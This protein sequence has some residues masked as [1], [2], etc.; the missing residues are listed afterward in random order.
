MRTAPKKMVTGNL[1][2]GSNRR[3]H[4][5]NRGY[6]SRNNNE[7]VEAMVALHNLPNHRDE[8]LLSTHDL[9]GLDD[10]LIAVVE[11]AQKQ[12]QQQQQQQHQHQ[13]QQQQK[14]HNQQQQEVHDTDHH[15]HLHHQ[16]QPSR[17][18]SN[19]ENAPSYAAV[20]AAAV[21]GDG[22][23]QYQYTEYDEAPGNNDY[24][25][26][27]E[28]PEHEKHRGDIP[29]AEFDHHVGAGGEEIEIARA[30]MQSNQEDGD[31]DEEHRDHEGMKDEPRSPGDENIY[32]K[33]Q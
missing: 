9:S 10:G 18:H 4:Q 22:E 12:Q 15:L 23:N 3:P 7:D 19:H 17:H 16:S 11:A 30:L 26:R 21:S 33:N 28:E 6:R 5:P 25:H 13:Q 14:D 2:N 24:N 1:R 29:V 32:F 27:D 31:L 20:A 8:S